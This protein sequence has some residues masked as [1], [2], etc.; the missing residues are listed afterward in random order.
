MF[1]LAENLFI[2]AHTRTIE[3]ERLRRDL[4]NAGIK[5]VVCVAPRNDPRFYGAN[6]G[7]D[8]AYR[9]V[10]FSDSSF[11]PEHLLTPLVKSLAEE[12]KAG[13]AVMIHCNAGRNRSALVAALVL[14]QL[15]MNAYSTVKHIRKIRPRA[16]ANPAFSRYLESGSVWTQ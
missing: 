12:V 11:I 10:P 3:T 2:R 6:S 4:R 8:V 14:V 13:R 15:G 9:H 1:K 16:L 5:T 7:F